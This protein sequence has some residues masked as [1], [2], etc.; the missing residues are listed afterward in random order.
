M[1][2]RE[3]DVESSVSTHPRNS[4]SH[5]ILFSTPTMKINIFAK[6][7]SKLTLYGRFTF[8]SWVGIRLVTHWRRET[9]LDFRWVS[10][11][12]TQ[13][14]FLTFGTVSRRYETDPRAQI[15]SSNLIKNDV[16]SRLSS[17]DV[18]RKMI[19]TENAFSFSSFCVEFDDIQF[20]SDVFH[21]L[22][23]SA[24]HTRY[25]KGATKKKCMTWH[26]SHCHPQGKEVTNKFPE[27]LKEWDQKPNIK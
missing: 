6:N 19:V 17:S 25:T 8:K 11:R 3:H 5:A 4:K 14:P 15:R 23:S 2:L 22:R 24:R 9:Y 18:L 10:T 7:L 26:K 21:Y 1:N 16:T 27:Q 13:D 20:T 12:I